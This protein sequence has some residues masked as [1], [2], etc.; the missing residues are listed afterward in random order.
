MARRSLPEWL[1]EGA[2]V[3]RWTRTHNGIDLKVLTVGRTTRTTAVADSYIWT[4]KATEGDPRIGA[5]GP[6]LQSSRLL[7]LDH[8]DVVAELARRADG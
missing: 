8:P 7:P 5:M 6:S 3:A 4:D 2:M 1:H